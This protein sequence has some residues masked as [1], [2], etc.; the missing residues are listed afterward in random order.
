M[1]V[2]T[3]PLLQQ[4]W[5]PFPL[6]IPTQSCFVQCSVPQNASVFGLKELCCFERL[7]AILTIWLCFELQKFC[8][9]FIYLYKLIL[10]QITEE[11]QPGLKFLLIFRNTS[12]LPYCCQ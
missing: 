10:P 8:N 9:A 7:W 2:V 12:D 1:H 4:G 6:C 11:I 5:L 3:S